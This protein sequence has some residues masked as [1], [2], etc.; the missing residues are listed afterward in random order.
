[1]KK[2]RFIGNLPAAAADACSAYARPFVTT[3]KL[4]EAGHVSFQKPRSLPAA[5]PGSSTV[6]TLAPATSLPRRLSAIHSA[7]ADM[8]CKLLGLDSPSLAES[9]AQPLHGFSKASVYGPTSV[10][11]TSGAPGAADLLGRTGGLFSTAATGTVATGAPAAH[12]T[13]TVPDESAVAAGADAVASRAG[14]G[15]AVLHERLLRRRVGECE[16]RDCRERGVPPAC[17]QLSHTGCPFMAVLLRTSH[18]PYVAQPPH[19]AGST[20]TPGIQQ[21]RPGVSWIARRGVPSLAAGSPAE[22]DDSRPAFWVSYTAIDC[23]GRRRSALGIG[24]MCSTGPC[25]G[26]R[27]QRLYGDCGMCR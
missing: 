7:V 19:S 13:A 17:H 2:E 20:H 5:Q 9:G 27:D 14:S 1:M 11:G 12:S 23:N 25:I 15:N 3:Q 4:Q 24:A 6:P 10:L 21:Q 8:A 26:V 18:H 22:H 16:S